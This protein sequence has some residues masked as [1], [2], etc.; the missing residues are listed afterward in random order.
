MGPF[1][2]ETAAFGDLSAEQTAALD[3]AAI[4][5]GV[6]ILQLMEVAGLQV[7]RTA[8]ELLGRRPGTVV[9]AAGGGNNGGDGLVS[10][11]L[12]EAWGCRLRCVLVAEPGRVGAAVR[13]QLAALGAGGTPL[14][15][16][17]DGRGIAGSVAGCD[18]AI[19]ALLGTGLGSAP[20]PRQASAIAAL[21]G[22]RTLSVDLPSG[23]SADTGE[24]LGECVEATATCTLTAVK[25][26]LWSAAG[27]HRAGDLWAADI[28]MPAAAWRAVGLEAPTALRGAALLRVPRSFAPS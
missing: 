1:P 3:A 9:V 19:D 13:H 14:T 15:T 26:G 20:R 4:D 8:W 6:V 21:A 17:E 11:R 25:H 27:R 22:A 2:P 18:L 28:G 24:A 10:A 7:A 23:L 12:L 16:G 5:L